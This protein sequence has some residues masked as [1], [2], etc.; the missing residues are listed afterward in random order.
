VEKCGYGKEGGCFIDVVL[1]SS[2]NYHQE[3]ATEITDVHVDWLVPW[4]KRDIFLIEM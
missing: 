4:G 2:T 1:H 3:H